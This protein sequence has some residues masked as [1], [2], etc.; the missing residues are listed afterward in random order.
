MKKVAFLKRFFI[1]SSVVLVILVTTGG[2]CTFGQDAHTQKTIPDSVTRSSIHE[3]DV[4]TFLSENKSLAET[5]TA[6][7]T[8]AKRRA[9]EMAR[10]YIRSKTRIEDYVLTF[11]A[12]DAISEG[13]VTV[14][15][16][17]D[18]GIADNSRYHVW[19]RAEVEYQLVSK[20]P[21]SPF[22]I[23]EKGAPLTVNVWTAKK[24]Y[25]QNDEITIYVLGNRPFYACVVNVNP[26][27]AITQLLPNTQRV[28]NQF[29]AGLTYKIPDRGDTFKLLPVLPYGRE[30][31]VVFASEASL[32]PIHMERGSTS[33]SIFNGSLK[34]FEEKIRPTH[35][36][37]SGTEFYKAV[38]EFTTRE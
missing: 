29:R 5:R 30:R 3:V 36:E 25:R 8:Q 9:V 28:A 26:E 27:G 14:L 1:V 38:W 18:L 6:A 24:A 19:I 15:A 12:L 31:I 13:A 21:A 32:G 7:F 4:Y 16:A 2:R 37:A 34:E 17:K 11:D 35:P 10:T 33:L 22:L 20:K 23:M